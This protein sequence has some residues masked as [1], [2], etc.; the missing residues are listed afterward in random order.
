M[1]H[2]NVSKQANI[3][4]TMALYTESL[5]LPRNF[6]TTSAM[7]SHA[8]FTSVMVDRNCASLVSFLI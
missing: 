3:F 1:L 7:E 8:F 4:S 5:V 2:R 6:D